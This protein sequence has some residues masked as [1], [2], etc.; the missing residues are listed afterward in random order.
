M[1][2]RGG[3]DGS[4]RELMPFHRLTMTSDG[5][6][7]TELQF[8][9]NAIVEGLCGVDAVGRATFCN[10]ALLK[11]TGYSQEEVLGKNLHKLLHYRRL[12]GAYYPEEACPLRAAIGAQRPVHVVNEYLFRKD[13]SYFPAEYWAHPLRQCLGR[14]THIVTLCDL[15][16]R[17]TSE[18]A[19]RISQERFQQI[20]THVNQ[21]FYLL[22]MQT[23]RLEYVSPAFETTTGY[24]CAEAYADSGLWRSIVQANHHARVEE[25]L[26][27]LYLGQEVSNEYQ[28]RHMNGGTRWIK[29]Q[30]NPILNADG[31]VHRVAGVAQDI[32]EAVQSKEVLRQSEEK[33]RRILASVPDV[34]WTS[35]QFGRTA[36][37]SPKVEAV[38]GY[39]ERELYA[40]NGE[41]WRTHLH[42]EDAGRV[43]AA[44]QTLFERHSAF[45]EE[46]RIR[47][48][49][50]EWIWLHDRAIRTHEQDGVLYADGI[51][52]DITRRKEA[53]VELQSKTAFLEAQAN[54]TID[55]ILVID[56]QGKKLLA[57]QR[58]YELFSVPPEIQAIDDDRA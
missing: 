12:D 32:T 6:L 45:D 9:L 48:K 46:Y 15:T 51:F 25:D 22:D 31:T 5:T 20:S 55:G 26:K 13:G 10:E 37:I 30:V 16:Q 21:I 52:C 49:D 3:S 11:L 34:L 33:F 57:N 47:R 35:D 27:V 56:D 39:T 18:E 24:S 41:I 28:I 40:A 8:I 38:M 19:L 14:T 7:S 17:K 54:S 44:Y 42:P 58:F 43:L 4:L 1:E 36:Y 2:F 29:N 50:G 23:E 53:E